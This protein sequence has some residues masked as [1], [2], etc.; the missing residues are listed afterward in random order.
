M[1]GEHR[2]GLTW[3][4]SSL[5]GW[6]IYG[7]NLTLQLA[8][9]PGF[10]PVLLGPLDRRNLYVDPLRSHLLDPVYQRSRDLRADWPA[11]GAA[12]LDMPVLVGLS[13]RLGRDFPHRGRREFAVAFFEATE[14]PPAADQVADWAEMVIAGSGWNAR[15]LADWGLTRVATVLQGIDDSLFHPAPRQQLFPGRFVIFS[16]GKLEY[17]KGQDMVL[18]AFR[19]FHARHP[20]ALLVVSWGNMWP[21]TMAGLDQSGLVTGLPEP[22]PGGRYQ[23]G[24][25]IANGVPPGALLD[26][27]F[28]PNHMMPPVLRECDLAVFPNRCEGGTNLVAMEAMACGV[29]V[30]LSANT[31]HLDLIED[32][33]CYVLTRQTAVASQP[34]GTDGWGESSVEELIERLEEAW[35]DRDEAARRGLRG[36]ATMRRHTWSRQVD[37]LLEVVKP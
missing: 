29:P 5:M 30:V 10:A 34:S 2:I 37:A 25:F 14:R 16:G 15:V 26:L 18:A 21:G 33:N 4:L 9:R 1:S 23:P 17:R 22:A 12:S 27:G 24:W 8:R 6:G 19:A 31:G 20:E 3:L 7:V 36:A 28:L 35:R 11:D 32:G 13:G